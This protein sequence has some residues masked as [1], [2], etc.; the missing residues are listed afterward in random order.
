MD[1]SLYKDEAQLDKATPRKRKRTTNKNEADYSEDEDYEQPTKKR[2]VKALPAVKSSRA[3][4]AAKKL[5]VTN[6][7]STE[8]DEENL[9]EVKK[10]AKKQVCKVQGIV[11]KRRHHRISKFLENGNVPSSSPNT[12]ENCESDFNNLFCFTRNPKPPRRSQMR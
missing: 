5:A 11:Q 6:D 3:A 2:S 10:K 9:M 1:L 4:A 12:V 8:S 7:E